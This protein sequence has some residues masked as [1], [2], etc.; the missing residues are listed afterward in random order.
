LA[1]LFNE[2][3]LIGEEIIDYALGPL[4]AL[5]LMVP[6]NYVLGGKYKGFN[7]ISHIGFYLG[8]ALIIA[9][10]VLFN[11]TFYYMFYFNFI[12]IGVGLGAMYGANY[13]SKNIKVSRISHK[14]SFYLGGTLIFFGVLL[15]WYGAMN[16]IAQ[17]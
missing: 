8:L 17:F 4:G 7:T 15:S 1:L 10:I 3:E 11:G 9:V 14:E 6:I 2:I 5:L 16:L 12:L 13:L